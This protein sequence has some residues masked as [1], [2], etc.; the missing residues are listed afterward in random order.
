MN[1]KAQRVEYLKLLEEAAKRKKLNA[2]RDRFDILYGW[3]LEF[4]NAT[5]EYH[6]CCLCA[7]NQ[8]GKTFTGTYID[9]VHLTG[10]YPEGWGGH[11]FDR[12]ITMWGLGY[13][14]LGTNS[15]RANCDA[16][17]WDPAK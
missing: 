16:A 11:K 13:L 8:I 5:A 15:E 1:S 7:A 17:N 12:Q 6:E 4:I 9:A 14:G 2:L 10:N 3:Q